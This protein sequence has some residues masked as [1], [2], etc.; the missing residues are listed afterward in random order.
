MCRYFECTHPTWSGKKEHDIQLRHCK[1]HSPEAVQHL[2]QLNK[3]STQGKNLKQLKGN[4]FSLPLVCVFK[5]YSVVR[6]KETHEVIRVV[7][8]GNM[9][10]TKAP[11]RIRGDRSKPRH[12][13]RFGEP[14]C[15]EHAK[16]ADDECAFP[17]EVVSELR[18]EREEEG[19]N[20]F[21]IFE[22][23]LKQTEESYENPKA[24]TSSTKLWPASTLKYDEGRCRYCR[25]KTQEK[26]SLC[27]KHLN[28]FQE[29]LA[30]QTIAP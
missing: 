7:F 15:Q 25:R 28:E 16:H 6:N 30:K 20:E 21:K 9:C 27:K 4:P 1:H 29:R 24:F 26:Q 14:L 5:P 3:E 18:D 10:C 11:R 17:G 13:N 8:T 19:R 23:T 12:P 2:L 22:D